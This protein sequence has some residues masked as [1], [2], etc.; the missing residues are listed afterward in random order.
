MY[1]L[2]GNSRKFET[3]KG[4][5]NKYVVKICLNLGC[6]FYLI[7]FS[8]THNKYIHRQAHKNAHLYIHTGADLGF[9]R[10][11]GGISKILTFFRST[12][13]IFSELSYSSKK[14]L[15]S[16]FGQIFCAAAKFLKKKTGQKSRKKGQKRSVT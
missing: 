15:F 4:K 1:R 7:L 11:R 6:I 3:I 13:L 8:L 2:K 16:C 5:R 12:K 14:I 10:G 9:S